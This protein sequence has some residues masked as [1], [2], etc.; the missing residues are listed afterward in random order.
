M[1]QRKIKHMEQ[2]R[3]TS[4]KGKKAW[5]SALHKCWQRIQLI[6]INVNF[7]DD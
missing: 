2:Q 5:R 1:S 3:V 7:L 4:I 6:E